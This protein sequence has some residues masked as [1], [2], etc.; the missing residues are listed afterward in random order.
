[1]PM[2]YDLGQNNPAEIALGI[3]AKILATANGKSLNSFTQ[4]KNHHETYSDSDRCG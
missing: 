3:I 1:M 2:G 4:N